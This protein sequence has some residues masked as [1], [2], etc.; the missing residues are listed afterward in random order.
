MYEVCFAF[1]A[2]A[3]AGLGVRPKPKSVP[4]GGAGAAATRFCLVRQFKKL[5]CTLCADVRFEGHRSTYACIQSLQRHHK[6]NH[7]S[8]GACAAIKLGKPL[9]GRGVSGWNSM[10]CHLSENMIGA[11]AAMS[12]LIRS[13]TLCKNPIQVSL[14][15]C[16]TLPIRLPLDSEYVP[17]NNKYPIPTQPD[18]AGCIHRSANN[19]PHSG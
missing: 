17:V 13:L 2:K 19:H 5:R 18:S 16:H 12:S 4:S 15:T 10:S 3:A 8:G 7:C 11:C 9:S 14:V 1:A 6:L